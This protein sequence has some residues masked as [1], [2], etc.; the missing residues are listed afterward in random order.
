MNLALPVPHLQPA[1]VSPTLRPAANLHGR[2]LFFFLAQLLEAPAQT[3]A[4]AP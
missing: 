3:A 1:F 4:M 2:P